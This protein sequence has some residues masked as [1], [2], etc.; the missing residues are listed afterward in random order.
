M[1]HNALI[2]NLSNFEAYT[3]DLE[4]K[5]EKELEL[6][7]GG[8]LTYT[9][10]LES[11]TN[12]VID[13]SSKII[14]AIFTSDANP[15]LASLRLK[16]EDIYYIYAPQLNVIDDA[17]AIHV[18]RY[19]YDDDADKEAAEIRQVNYALRLAQEAGVPT[20]KRQA[21]GIYA[22]NIIL[23][24]FD[25][26]TNFVIP[27]PVSSVVESQDDLAL[28][29]SC[30][31]FVCDGNVT[32]AKDAVLDASEF[33]SLE[34][35]SEQIH[36]M[37]PI[38]QINFV[39]VK[40][41]YASIDVYG[42][43][44]AQA[45]VAMKTN[46]TIAI[47]CDA[48]MIKLPVAI[49]VAVMDNHIVLDGAT[50]ETGGSLIMSATTQVSET[51]ISTTGIVPASLAINVAVN[52]TDV[53]IKDSTINAAGTVAA[54]ATSSLTQSAS[55]SLPKKG[56]SNYESGGFFT[57]NVAVHEANAIVS[58]DT[59]I[60]A[61]GDVRANANATVKATG[62]AVSGKPATS[63]TVDANTKIKNLTVAQLTKLAPAMIDAIMKTVK[64]KANNGN[65]ISG[66]F[67]IAKESIDKGDSE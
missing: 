16:T 1:V 22:K 25:D 18:G 27:I 58:G 17:L 33:V 36:G 37:L 21:A 48:S 31:N 45:G 53:E 26:D 55:A 14:A 59:N 61:G 52:Y 47:A 43:I 24:G 11:F 2:L 28:D 19:T 9:G 50:I 8:T 29:L 13:S 60:T 54:Q 15:L 49:A 42:T 32:I 38:P 65:K 41:G 44:K 46:G 66:G 35:K 56:E 3:D 62:K 12:Y 20:D 30:F 4:G 23:R 40:V 64:P 63:T 67:D 34:A 51:A 7:S 39:T 57:I 10:A 6:A 5:K